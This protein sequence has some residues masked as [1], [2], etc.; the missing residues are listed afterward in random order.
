LRFCT[1]CINVPVPNLGPESPGAQLKIKTII[2]KTA[3]IRKNILN[4]LNISYIPL[5]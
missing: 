2:K 1:G 3:E 4:S 5:N